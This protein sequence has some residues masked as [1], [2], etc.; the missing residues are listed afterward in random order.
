MYAAVSSWMALI[1]LINLLP[2]MPLDGGRIMK[3]IAYSIDSKVGLVFLIVA[4]V[5][6]VIISI[7]TGL[8]L[9]ALLTIVGALD[10]WVEYKKR[11]ERDPM[12]GIQILDSACVYTLTL[13]VLLGLMVYMQ[14]I[15]GA[16][17][18]LDV[19]KS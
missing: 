9:F 6:S 11:V 4:L 12:Y 19:L 1:N 5:A 14:G 8:V 3:S 16:Q 15:P 17:H 7:A 18:A 13:L 10:L 2:I